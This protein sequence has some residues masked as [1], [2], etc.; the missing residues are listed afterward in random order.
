MT[1]ITDGKTPLT[2]KLTYFDEIIVIVT[3]NFKKTNKK[4][5]VQ[6]FHNT[7]ENNLSNS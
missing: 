5:F 3:M 2:L 6:K 7:F 4:F 1:Y